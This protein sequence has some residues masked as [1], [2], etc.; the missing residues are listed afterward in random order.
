MD[1]CPICEKEL[2]VDFE[3][4][5]YVTY[6]VYIHCNFC[7]LYDYEYWCGNYR[8]SIGDPDHDSYREFSWYYTDSREDELARNADIKEA[9]VKIK[10]KFT[11]KGQNYG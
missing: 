10:K 5:Y 6:G 8:E 3:R 2:T 7:N 9:C 4:D 11:E 1:K